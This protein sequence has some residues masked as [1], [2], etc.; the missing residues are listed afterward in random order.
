MS[1]K[2][3]KIYKLKY[4]PHFDAKI[5]WQL[6]KNQIEDE[7]YIAHHAFYPFIHYQQVMRKFPKKFIKD[8]EIKTRDNPKTRN[9]MYSAHI[10]RYIYEYYAYRLNEIYNQYLQEHGIGRCSIA[11]RTNLHKNNIHF[12]KEAF[13]RIRAQRNCLVIL[14]DFTEYFDHIDHAYLKQSICKLLGVSSLPEDHYSVFRSITKYSWMELD[15]IREYK[16]L[17]RLAF[18][19]L[20]RIFSPDEFRKFKKDHLH[21]NV[22]S[23]GI[24]QG[25]AISAVYSNIYLLD[26]DI[27][28]ND[29]CRKYGGFYRRYCD[30]FIIILPYDEVT[31]Q[32][33]IDSIYRIKDSIK[34]LTLQPKKTQL[35]H[36]DNGEIVSVNECYLRDVPNGNSQV[37][38]LGFTFD[39]S[40]V[41]IRSKTIA[42]YY[43]RM[44]SKADNIVEADQHM[45]DG[46]KT[47]RRKIYRL[48]SYKG[49]NASCQNKR[50]GNFLSYVDRAA[51]VFGE[52]PIKQDTKRSWS[53]LQKR[54]HPSKKSGKSCK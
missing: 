40:Q 35:L 3:P 28:M 9:I 30:D 48:Y 27:Q 44:Y 26:F 23:Y 39:G 14:G 18:N 5:H 49:K 10:D 12:A 41:R 52:E 54:L 2:K 11:Y 13:D 33:Y 29:F 19:K 8:K 21:R 34:N 50:R 1:M 22:N 53:K 43:E 20:D 24:P 32:H 15:E 45:L 37:S 17:N 36:Y 31:N 7:K 25:S 6:V 47:S 4:Y 16:K 46:K 38:Y 51:K 42:K